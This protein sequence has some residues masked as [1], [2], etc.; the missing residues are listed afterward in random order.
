MSKLFGD[1][2]YMI[3]YID[4]ILIL[5]REDESDKDH[6][7]NIESVLGRREAKGFRANPNMSFFMQPE[8]D[9]LGYL[10]TKGKIKPQPKKVEAMHRMKPPNSNTQLKCFLGIYIT[11]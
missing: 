2:E 9:Y 3:L 6:L 4:D 1:L 11:Y 8:I 5:Q 10:L 7:K